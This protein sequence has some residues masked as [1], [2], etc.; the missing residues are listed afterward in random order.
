MSDRT[1]ALYASDDSVVTR[2]RRAEPS[3]GLRR[4]MEDAAR[5]LNPFLREAELPSIS[6]PTATSA[7]TR[8]ST[9]QALATDWAMLGWDMCRAMD[10][11]RSNQDTDE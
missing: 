7:P 10:R 11:V 1:N 2:Y 3:S 8:I 4:W 5:I 6:S 9:A